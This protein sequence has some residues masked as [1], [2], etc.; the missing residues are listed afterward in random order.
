VSSAL[1]P[2]TVRTT[3]RSLFAPLAIRGARC[4]VAA[5]SSSLPPSC[6]TLPHVAPAYRSMGEHGRPRN[7]H[8]AS[9]ASASAVHE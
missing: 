7:V 5:E 6:S 1:A 4:V 9:A 8:P 2:L 3:R